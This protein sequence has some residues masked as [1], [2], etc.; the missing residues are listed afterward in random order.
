MPS[1]HTST[2]SANYLCSASIFSSK[3]SSSRPQRPSYHLCRISDLLLKYGLS[4]FPQSIVKLYMS[5]TDMLLL[6]CI[7]PLLY[8]LCSILCG[9]AQLN[10]C[11]NKCARQSGHWIIH[12]VHFISISCTVDISIAIE[13]LV[14]NT[15]ILKGMSTNIACLREQWLFLLL[16]QCAK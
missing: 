8:L 12:V 6:H 14:L 4:I 9:M 1:L 16:P 5:N 10:A 13:C 15:E 7:R 11:C 3:G 2:L